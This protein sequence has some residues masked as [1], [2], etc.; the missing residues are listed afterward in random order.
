MK[1]ILKRALTSPGLIAIVAFALR[2]GFL[3]HV[4]ETGMNPVR[5]DLPFGYELGAVA[6]SIASGHGFSSPLRWFATG[7]TAWFG[8][9]YPYL[10]AGVFKLFGIYTYTSYM[11][12][13]TFNIAL[14]ALTCI[15][16]F[17]AGKRT[18]GLAVGAG[19]AWAWI[20]LPTAVLY[21]LE[22]IWDTAFSALCMAVMLYVTLLLRDSPRLRNWAGYGALWAFCALLNASLLATLPFLVAWVILDLRRKRAPW[23]RGA[24]ACVLLLALGLIPWTV[25]NA[26]VFHK[27]IPVR[28]NF[29]LE[30]WL[31]NNPGTV[32]NDNGNQHPN[33][34]LEEAKLYRRMGEPAYMAEKQREAFEFIRSHPA[35]AARLTFHRVVSTWLG[36][37][38]PIQDSWGSEPWSLRLT[39][40]YE[41]SFSLLA[42]LGALLAF[43]TR[44]PEA[45]PY[46][47]V[48]LSY[49]ALFYVT[50]GSGR[51]RHPIDPIL[52]VL[53]VFAITCAIR[54]LGRSILERRRRAG[55]GATARES[56]VPN[57]VG[58]GE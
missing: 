26:I 38:D 45:A 57:R 46:A 39:Q 9:I 31:G 5:E 7:P 53:A 29:G 40:I 23:V 18:F 32:D 1:S 34:N 37:W 3:V 47:L 55:A 43:R 2:M 12:L 28:G 49:P 22:W 41:V 15:P 56:L 13:V 16:I 25:R 21:S 42:F 14:S 30:F 24:A 50:H 11:I 33:D 36:S 51:Y 44:N 27:F 19:A 58:A 20:F 48:I 4:R 17:L 52:T 6:A 10:T 8:P 35:D 54:P